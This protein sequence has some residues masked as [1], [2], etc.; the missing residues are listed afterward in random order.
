MMDTLVLRIT[1]TKSALQLAICLTLLTLNNQLFA[2]HNGSFADIRPV[3]GLEHPSA[4]EYISDMSDDGLSIWMSSTRQGSRNFRN[5]E[6]YRSTRNSID[7]PFGA[8]ERID[9]L[10]RSGTEDGHQTLSSD[11]LTTYFASE[12]PNGSGSSIWTAT[13][14]TLDSEWS[15]PVIVDIG[16][17][18]AYGAPRLS[19]DDL[20]LYFN[21]YRT[22]FRM[23]MFKMERE[24]PS[25]PFG[26]PE[27]IS[28]INTSAM[29]EFQPVLSSDELAVFYSSSTHQPSNLHIKVATRSSKDEPFGESVDLDDFGMRSEVNS[30]FTNNWIPFISA[31]WPADGSKLYFTGNNDLHGDW[32]IYEAT[33]S[34]DQIG[35]YSADGSLDADDLNRLTSEI[36]SGST[37]RQYDLDQSGNVDVADRQF[38]VTDL[39][40]TWIG[41]ANLDGEFNS[42]DFIE[43]FQAGKYETGESAIWNE[44]DW[45]GDE[46][47]DS[48]DFIAAFQDG[49]YE[50]GARSAVASVPEPASWIL[51]TLGL[52]SVGRIRRR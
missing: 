34:V 20:T 30:S 17:L 52:I 8:P 45:N 47:F 7:E 24:S 25:E 5:W 18:P 31:D 44:G 38:W 32:E 10:S 51:L 3:P 21:G 42:T 26:D 9:S 2:Q 19:S 36:R 23:D 29:A 12:A 39:K 35:D 27:P 41:D 33:W 15:E 48:G 50:T 37:H 6:F 43:V 1:I 28:E 40:S 16:N 11:R 49:G 46:L 4:W 14:D 22:S 13:R